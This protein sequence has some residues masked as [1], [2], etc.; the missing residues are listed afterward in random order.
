VK[1]SVAGI[2]LAGGAS[3]RMGTPKAGL[4]HEGRTFLAHVVGALRGAGIGDVTVVSGSAHDA[5]LAALPPGDDARILRNADP[6]RGQLSSLKVAL[7]ALCA[8]HRRPDAAVMALVDH[9]AVRPATV[10]RL[11]AAWTDAPHAG[12][13][14]PTFAERRGHPVLFACCVWDELLATPDELGARAVVRADASRVLDVP[15][16]D[17]GVRIDVDT[18]DDFRRLTSAD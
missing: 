3:R 1:R 9:P 10:A 12:V 7:A 11:V 13:A 8:R 14:V 18:P 4:L 2:V 15:V 6:D 17:P 5:V 16:D